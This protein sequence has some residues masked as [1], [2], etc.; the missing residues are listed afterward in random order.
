MKHNQKGEEGQWRPEGQVWES[1]EAGGAGT[2]GGEGDNAGAPLPL[3]APGA[4]P[5]PGRSAGPALPL[6]IPRL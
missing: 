3:A 4:R 6:L 1:E 2:D 5:R